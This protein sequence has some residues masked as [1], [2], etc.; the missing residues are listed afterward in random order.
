VG[1][2]YDRVTIRME[3]SDDFSSPAPGMSPR[4]EVT[5]AFVVTDKMAERI[6][7]LVKW[8][9]EDSVSGEPMR[10]DMM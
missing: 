2:R 9:W 7:T 6:R 3:F 5:W 10:L 4:N 1:I 8:N